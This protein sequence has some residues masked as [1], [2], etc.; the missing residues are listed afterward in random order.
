MAGEKMFDLFEKVLIKERNLPGTIVDITMI[1][2][3][4]VITVESDI[5]GE[6][7]NGY[8]DRFPLFECCESDLQQL[9]TNEK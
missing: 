3:R 1:K 5:E 8:G 4:K 7:E 9:I 6:Q 2:G